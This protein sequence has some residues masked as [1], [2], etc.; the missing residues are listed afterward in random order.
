M[1]K[2]G[3]NKSQANEDLYKVDLTV[4]NIYLKGEK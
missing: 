3:P 4:E 1:K 2:L